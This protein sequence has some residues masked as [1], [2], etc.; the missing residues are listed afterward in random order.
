MTHFD[1][2]RQSVKSVR[3]IKSLGLSAIG[4]L[5]LLNPR[6]L[7]QNPYYF[8]IGLEKKCSIAGEL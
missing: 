3:W 6:M 5:I 7:Q 2:S 4:L 8:A 1:R